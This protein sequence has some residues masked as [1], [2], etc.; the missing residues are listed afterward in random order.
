MTVLIATAAVNGIVFGYILG[1]LTASRHV[2]RDTEMAYV[3][4]HVDG[5]EKGM[6]DAGVSE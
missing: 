1:L 4:G 2:A 3:T 6:Q 5:Y